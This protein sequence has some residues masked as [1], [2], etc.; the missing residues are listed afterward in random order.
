MT[1]R[2]LMVE[3][4]KDDRFCRRVITP[5]V[6]SLPDQYIG[7]RGITDGKNSLDLANDLVV[8]VREW[9]LG[10]EPI[11]LNAIRWVAQKNDST[12]GGFGLKFSKEKVVE[13]VRVT[14]NAPEIHK[15]LDVSGDNPDSATAGRWSKIAI[16]ER[17]W[18][19]TLKN[20]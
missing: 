6:R 16:R 2:G 1:V 10:L 14:L 5:L 18:T 12:V 3:L 7:V 13:H 11:S 20:S 8:R 17:V 9:G 15:F 4:A 19:P